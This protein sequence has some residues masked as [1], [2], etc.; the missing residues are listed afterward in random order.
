MVQAVVV[1]AVQVVPAGTRD[2]WD[3]GWVHRSLESAV[4]GNTRRTDDN[5]FDAE[6]HSVAQARTKK[7]GRGSIVCIL[8][9]GGEG[10][11][12]RDSKRLS[13][14][15]TEQYNPYSDNPCG[16]DKYRGAACWCDL[17]RST[18]LFHKLKRKG[19]HAGHR[20]VPGGRRIAE[21]TFK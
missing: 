11:V 3:E 1:E 6:H 14:R 9:F 12:F 16:Q 10:D 13:A 21:H 20:P 15:K 18:E 17:V 2:K 7:M 8:L 4:R 5:A 19:S